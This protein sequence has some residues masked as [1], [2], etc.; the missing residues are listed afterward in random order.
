MPRVPSTSPATNNPVPPYYVHVAQSNF[1]DSNGRVLI[2]RGVNLSGSDKAPVDKPS[3]Q[4][5]DFWETAENGG[6]SFI[7][8]PLNLEDGSADVHLA[9]LR[10]WGF[11]VIRYCVTWEALEHA[12]PRKYDFEFMDYTVRVLRKVKEYG[13][14]VFMDPHQDVWSRYSGGSGAPYWTLPACGLNPRNFTSTLACILHSEYPLPTSPAPETLPAMIWSTNYTRLVSQTVWTLFFAGRQFAPRAIIDGVNIQDWLQSHFIDAFGLLADKI[15]DA[16]DLLDE[17]IIGWDSINE[18]GEG[19][20]GLENLNEL[21]KHQALKKGPTPTPIQSI[22]LGSGIPQTVDN[23]TFGPLGPAKDGTVTIDPAG[24]TIW[25]DPSIESSDGTNTKWGWK[26]DPGWK[27]GEC[28]WALHSVWDPRTGEAITSDYF[29][30]VRPEKGAAGRRAS[31]SSKR[32]VNFVE[33]YWK[34]HWRRYSGRIKRAHPEAIHFIQPPVFVPPPPLDGEL[35]GRGAYSAHYY[36]GLTL[37]TR[38]WN[39]FNADALGLLRGRYRTVLGS[40]KIGTPAI[41]ASLRDQLGILKSDAHDILGPSYPTLIGEIGTPMDMDGKKAYGWT[42]GGKF[43][44]DYSQQQKALDASLN[45]ADGVNA[46]SYTMWTYCPDS[47][48]QWGDGWNLEDLSIW[49]PSDLRQA[50]PHLKPS[51]SYVMGVG[52]SSSAALIN[53]RS[54]TTSLSSGPDADERVPQPTHTTT[55]PP[56]VFPHTNPSVESLDSTN[57]A[58]TVSNE[59]QLR[60]RVRSGDASPTGKPSTLKPT[61]V[62]FQQSSVS[63]PESRQDVEDG[64]TPPQNPWAFFTDGTR[65]VGAFARPYPQALVGSS[66]TIDFNLEK[67]TFK[68]V[69]TV[70]AHDR[71]PHVKGADAGGDKKFGTEIYLPLVHFAAEA[72]TKGDEIPIAAGVSTDDKIPVDAM[73]SSL[74]VDELQSGLRTRASTLDSTDSGPIGRQDE[75]RASG[76]SSTVMSSTLT[77][78]KSYPSTPFL[79]APSCFSPIIPS[80]AYDITVEASQGTTWSLDS[81]N[82]TIKWFYTVPEPGESAKEYSIVI[83]RKDG[84]I[85]CVANGTSSKPFDKKTVQQDGEVEQGGGSWWGQCCNDSGCVLM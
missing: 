14:K 28:I 19:F 45:A 10:G 23:W 75:H 56:G 70:T 4:L 5:D 51:R 54:R 73:H 72:W 50:V 71:C 11:N 63:F 3:Q 68:L 61:T 18:P 40:V 31:I 37:M 27:L 67:A 69:V 6:E 22:R 21:P 48:H 2:L 38:H 83:K 65:A 12:G 43:K 62:T 47:T 16:G 64:Y 41:R 81:Q 80:S 44:G 29:A 42:D 24:R 20:L 46:L 35:M 30:Y 55:H 57:S 58:L 7:G 9:R 76:S 77:L 32:M 74:S 33:D 49:S 1:L 36:D 79:A 82:Q 85:K 17:C 66:K 25:A 13:F 53:N 15:R 60:S 34:P 26:R 84:A 52:T 59:Y 78:S 39:W 8:R